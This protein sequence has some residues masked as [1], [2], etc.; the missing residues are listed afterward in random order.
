MYHFITA[1][2]DATIHSEL[3]NQNTGLDE[4]LEI[5][6]TVR[7]GYQDISRILIK[8]NIDDINIDDG[9]TFLLKLYE[10]VSDEIPIDYSI[11]AHAVSREWD[12]GIGTR[13]DEISTSG[14]NWINRKDSTPWRDYPIGLNESGS[15][16]GGTWYA[17]TIATQSFSY[18]SS[19]ITLDVTNIV[20]K[21]VSGSIQNNGFILK[22]KSEWEN[23]STGD[24]GRLQFF[25]KETNTIYQPLLLH[26]KIDSTYSSGS[27]QLIPNT[28]IKIIPVNLKHSYKKNSFVNIEL[29]ATELYPQKTF[30]NQYKNYT[31]YRLPITSYYQIRDFITNDIII[32][33]S[34]YSKISCNENGNYFKFN[35]KNW[36]VNRDYFFEFKVVLNDIEEYFQYKHL[37]F[38][39]EK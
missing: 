26:Q 35:T 28:N 33:F 1:S 31:P 39:L 14:V 9:D 24:Y 25:S 4:I 36:E 22:Y 3:P 30:Q 20:H 13:F 5:S 23:S 21:W 7:S 32:P 10:V 16:N 17:D 2:Q 19:D 15:I 38:H 34:D 6:K 27:I 37:T 11:Y 29:I 12:M 18:Q 8:F